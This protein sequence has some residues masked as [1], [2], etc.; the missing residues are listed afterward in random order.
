MT[1]SA[2]DAR[3]AGSIPENYDRYLGSLLFQPYAED[4]VARLSDLKQ[5]RILEIAAGTGVVTKE[6]SRTLPQSVEIVATDLNEAMLRVC[7]QKL[8]G[9]AV[10]FRQADAQQLPFEDESFDAVVAQFGVMFLPDKRAG[11]REARRVLRPGARYL[12]N[13]WDRVERNQVTEV[14]SDVLVR[15][16]PSD[17]PG[18]MRR[19]PFGYFDQDTI[20]ADLDS[21]GFRRVEIEVVAKTSP[22]TAE[23][24]AIGL[25]QGT[26]IRGEIEQRDASRLDEVTRAVTAALAERFGTGTFENPMSA[27]VVSAWRD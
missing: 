7:E 27:L 20:K 2:T 22:G 18:F 17:P 5:G 11:Y 25:C 1:T 6:L 24:A 23:Q 15:L 8:R 3:F 13:V 14:T 9:S 12:F 26:P 10:T 21:A 4:L 16:F 19:T